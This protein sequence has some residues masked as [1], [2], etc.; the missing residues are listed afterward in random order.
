MVRANEETMG[1]GKM[2]L[3]KMPNEI[4]LMILEWLCIVDPVTFLGA[5][6]GVSRRFRALM[7]GVQRAPS[8]TAIGSAFDPEG[9][10][11]TDK[12]KAITDAVVSFNPLVSSMRE[13]VLLKWLAP[14]FKSQPSELI[15]MEYGRVAKLVLTQI[16]TKKN[17]LP[18]EAWLQTPLHVACRYKSEVLAAVL[19]K[20]GHQFGLLKNMLERRVEGGPA[21]LTMAC[22]T[23][24]N[25]RPPSVALA[26]L[27]LHAGAIVDLGCESYNRTA[28]M[29][30]CCDRTVG[31]ELAID[32]MKL[33][34]ERGAKF[35]RADKYSKTAFQHACENGRVKLA[36]AFLGMTDTGGSIIDVTAKVAGGQTLLH[37]AH[38]RCMQLLIDKAAE[39]GVREIDF[40][41]AKDDRGYTPLMS[42]A[43][44]PEYQ[45]DRED[46][47]ARAKIL[48]ANEADINATN[49]SGQTALA[50]ASSS[51]PHLKYGFIKR[52]LDAGG[53]PYAEDKRGNT[54]VGYLEAYG[55]EPLVK[56]L[57]DRI[58]PDPDREGSPS[59]L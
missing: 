37:S 27:L 17:I 30:L 51:N 22:Y 29:E 52:L 57:L 36:T 2:T 33:L 59:L 49:E 40:V 50:I 1:F 46:L 18:D 39:K 42:A 58:E 25:K 35:N 19:I 47:A 16:L 48:L 9:D 4:L 54:P 23:M 24:D 15:E 21:P 26:R 5:I 28:L 55:D 38:S 56:L 11:A 12:L 43:Y 31:P 10:L 7:T 13:K 20:G 34:V 32:L 41:N 44:D 14:L 8:E 6:P 53:D 45:D 3:D